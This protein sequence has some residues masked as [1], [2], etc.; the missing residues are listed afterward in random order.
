MIK[1]QSFVGDDIDSSIRSRLKEMTRPSRIDH[2]FRHTNSIIEVVVAMDGD[3]DV[4]CAIV[5]DDG[6]KIL[7][8]LHVSNVHMR[9]GVM[10]AMI[11]DVLSRHRC[12]VSKISHRDFI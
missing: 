6:G 10:S 5:H 3:I 11:E 1:V 12:M 9:K 8:I 4:G 7:D 2:L